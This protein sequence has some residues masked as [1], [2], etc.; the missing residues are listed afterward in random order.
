MLL[1]CAAYPVAAKAYGHE[2]VERLSSFGYGWY[3]GFI[4]GLLIVVIAWLGYLGFRRFV[5]RRRLQHLREL[6]DQVVPDT[7]ER[8]R[9]QHEEEEEWHGMCVISMS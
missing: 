9:R 1:L 7:E 5:T 6:A 2:E 4:C 8:A 3:M